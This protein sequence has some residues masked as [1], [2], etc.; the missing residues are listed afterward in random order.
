VRPPS[1]AQITPDK[2]RSAPFIDFCTAVSTGTKMPRSE[3]KDASKYRVGFPDSDILNALAQLARTSYLK[4]AALVR[5]ARTLIA[6]RDALLPKLVSGQIRVPLTRDELVVG[7][8]D[9]SSA[10]ISCSVQV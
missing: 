1:T 4:V 9:S 10:A 7:Q 5:E 2:S 3:W 8:F 6:V